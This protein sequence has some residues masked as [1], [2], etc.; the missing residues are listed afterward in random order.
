MIFDARMEK[1]AKNLVS[2]SQVDTSREKIAKLQTF[3]L[4]YFIGKNYFLDDGSK[5]YLIFQPIWDISEYQLVKL[6]QS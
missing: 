4:S 5:N 1:A 2:K 6:R 3:D